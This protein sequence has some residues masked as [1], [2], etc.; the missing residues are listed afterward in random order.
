MRPRICGCVPVNT[1]SVNIYT[2][3]SLPVPVKIIVEHRSSSRVSLGKKEVIVR[4]PKHISVVDKEKTLK[5]FIAWAKQQIQEKRYYQDQQQTVADYQDRE[6]RVYHSVFKIQLEY[7]QSGKNRLSYRNDHILKMYLLEQLTERKKV[8]E[9]QRFLL[10]FTEKYFLPQLQ[11]RT[12][13]WNEVYFKE[14][15]D[16][17]VIKHTVSC[18]G[19]CT[20]GRRLQFSTRLLLMPTEIIDYVIIHE[21]AH[22]KEMNHS[23]KFWQHVEQA[24]PEYKLH[25]KW[26]QQHGNKI[27][28]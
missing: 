9:I 7:I 2:A 28:F 10:R 11:Q 25:R 17:V 3:D 4:L 19:S 20:V 8:Q 23:A 1:M 24:M 14:K 15:I 6:I 21:L 27:N 16:K 13:Y 5:Q 12:L 18:W 26:L 22:L